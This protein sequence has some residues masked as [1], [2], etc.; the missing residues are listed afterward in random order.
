MRNAKRLFI[1]LGILLWVALPI[2]GDSGLRMFVAGQVIDKATGKGIPDVYFYITGPGYSYDTRTNKNGRF[3]I[4]GVRSGVYRVYFDSFYEHTWGLVD[5]HGY[6]PVK[7]EPERIIVKEGMNVVGVKIW[8]EKGAVLEGRFSDC[9]GDGLHPEVEEWNLDPCGGYPTVDYPELCVPLVVTCDTKFGWI[10]VFGSFE[11]QGDV[12]TGYRFSGIPRG[13]KCS[14]KVDIRGYPYYY[15][16]NAFEIERGKDI[17]K[18]DIYLSKG[19]S[20]VVGRVFDINT[21]K[22][23]KAIVR[24]KKL[25][26]KITLQQLIEGWWSGK[27][28]DWSLLLFSYQNFYVYFKE[29]KEVILSEGSY[30]FKCIPPGEYGVNLFSPHLDSYAIV[31]VYPGKNE[32]DFAVDGS[33]EAAERFTQYLRKYKRELKTKAKVIRGKHKR[34]KRKA[35]RRIKSRESASSALEG[36]KYP[37]PDGCCEEEEMRDVKKS[38]EDICRFNNWKC[39]EDKLNGVIDEEELKKIKECIIRACKGEPFNVFCFYNY[40]GGNRKKCPR[41]DDLGTYF[42]CPPWKHPRDVFLCPL[43]LCGDAKVLLPYTLFHEMIHMCTHVYCRGDRVLNK[44][45]RARAEAIAYCTQYCFAHQRGFITY[46]KKVC[47]SLTN[48]LK[49]NHTGGSEQ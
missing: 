42:P 5:L 48:D 36:C 6:V 4:K 11:K 28:Y 1:I 38:M 37:K 21:R 3:L 31:K 45:E 20:I 14:L 26:K 25:K 23:V 32:I 19:N 8:M 22:P 12:I 43:L 35:K 17:L 15:S 49:N 16:E 13:A 18:K 47:D 40:S 41:D 34:K 46:A 39:V 7:V 27:F 29:K 33:K 30:F 44:K 10:K 9:E 24:F 2:W